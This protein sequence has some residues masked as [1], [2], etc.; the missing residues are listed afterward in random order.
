M[1]S[2]NSIKSD[3][4]KIAKSSNFKGLYFHYNSLSSNIYL[5]GIHNLL[6]ILGIII[7]LG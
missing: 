6:V 1:K 5:L 3:K 4:L 7:L 2:T